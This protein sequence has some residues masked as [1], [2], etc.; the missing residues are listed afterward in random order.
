MLDIL[1][2]MQLIVMTANMNNISAQLAY[3]VKALVIIVA[4]II[5]RRESLKR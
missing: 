2:D 5:Q 1:Q 4:V 3:I